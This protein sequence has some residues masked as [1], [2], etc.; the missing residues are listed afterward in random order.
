MKTRRSYLLP[1]LLVVAACGDPA[2][3]EAEVAEVR[4]T[5]EG[6]STDVGLTVQFTAQAFDASGAA[7]TGLPVTWESSTESVATI[8]DQ[9]VW[10]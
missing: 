1:A 4:I 8:T 9:G 7:V 3:P 10:R 6:A 5:P 2:A